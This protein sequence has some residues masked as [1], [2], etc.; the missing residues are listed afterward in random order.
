[1]NI[2]R[3]LQEYFSNSHQ[4]PII[5]TFDDNTI[6]KVCHSIIDTFKNIP[7]IEICVLQALNYCFY[8][9]LDNV[10]VHSSKPYG[11]TVSRYSEKDKMIQVLVVDDGIGI[12]KSLT[13]NP[14]YKDISEEE[15][16]RICLN[17]AV[18]DGKGMGFGM[19]SMMRMINTNGLC[20]KIHSGN[21]ILRFQKGKIDIEETNYWEGTL[22]YFELHSD[23][24]FNANEVLD[25]RTDCESSFEES[26]FDESFENLW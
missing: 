18:T 19:Y 21:K 7:E 15:A 4:S 20:L 12:W 23:K 9:I 22:I 2:D 25:N 6:V 11:T 17:D 10:L 3:I 16:L 13:M 14:K 8:E 1:M 24:E 26:F 5:E